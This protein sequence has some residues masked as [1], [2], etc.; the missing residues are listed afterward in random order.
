VKSRIARLVAEYVDTLNQGKVLSPERYCAAHADI[1][2]ELREPVEAAARLGEFKLV[3]RPLPADTERR[4]ARRVLMP[5]L[6]K[7]AQRLAQQTQDADG[8]T[9][10]FAERNQLLLLLLAFVGSTGAM[11][12]PIRGMLRLMKLVFLAQMRTRAT[13]H[14]AYAYDFIP[15]KY[16]PHAAGVY[17][18]L[19]V[20]IWAGLVQ[21]TDFDEDG[22][23]IIN[24]NDYGQMAE[25]EFGTA[26]A[27]YQLT[28][29]GRAYADRLRQSLEQADPCLHHELARLKVQVTDMS[30][31]RLLTFV[32]EQ[33]PE[34]AIES[35]LLRRMQ[36]QQE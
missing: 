29:E 2:D 35:E 8:S 24:R 19:Q 15:Y 27:L 33:Y 6:R 17:D 10:E 1:A 34:Y 32:Y 28:P 16:G 9:T 12:A 26:N 21:R 4:M 3:P 5:L 7:A 30:L 20:L 11:Y 22:L 18:D 14:L 31:S 25:I 13:R 23:P 36:G